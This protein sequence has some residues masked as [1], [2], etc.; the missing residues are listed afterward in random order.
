MQT[1]ILGEPLLVCSTEPMTGYFRDGNCRTME[2]DL[3]S[4]TVCTIIND[5]FLEYSKQMG[6]DL[7]TP[8]PQYGFPGL[9]E[10]DRWCVCALR[11]KEA[12]EAGLAP[13]ID[14][15]A[16]SIHAIKYISKEILLKYA[17]KE[18]N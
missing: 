12:Y 7:K 3:G 17:I 6:N 13:L 11:W 14:P 15:K 10:G 9:V 18:S 5:E 8:L 2:D 16:T 1:N 4:H